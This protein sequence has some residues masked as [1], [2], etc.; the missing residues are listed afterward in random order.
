MRFV[1][2]K[3]RKDILKR[4]LIPLFESWGQRENVHNTDRFK[5]TLME[6]KKLNFDTCKIS[7][8]EYI[9]KDYK[10]ILQLG[11]LEY[12]CFT[13][14]KEIEK[15]IEIDTTEGYDLPIC[16]NCLTEML[17]ILKTKTLSLHDL[18]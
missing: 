15:A 3:T 18:T 13:C 5:Q 7:D 14:E 11:A 8:I 12:T 10:K 4:E 2:L 16:E 6:L 9:L 17:S 1:E